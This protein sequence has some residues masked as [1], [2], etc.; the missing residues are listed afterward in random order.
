MDVR[1]VINASQGLCA[2][3]F[4][5]ESVIAAWGCQEEAFDS[6]RLVRDAEAQSREEGR[7]ALGR[8][9]GFL[10]CNMGHICGRVP[11][12]EPRV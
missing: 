8:K 9:L 4:A 1:S 5:E 11:R 10:T 2:K 3:L 12:V 6:P 7:R